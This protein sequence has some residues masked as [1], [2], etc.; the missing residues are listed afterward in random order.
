MAFKPNRYVLYEPGSVLHKNMSPMDPSE[1]IH[2]LK[3][4][5]FITVCNICI[6]VLL[7]FPLNKLQISLYTTPPLN[8]VKQKKTK[9]TLIL[10]VTFNDIPALS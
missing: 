10:S 2:Y 6:H 1:Q 8:R 4:C 5:I 3:H 9:T 7:E